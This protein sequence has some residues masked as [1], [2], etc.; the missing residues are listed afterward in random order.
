VR[1]ST[2]R[3]R[4]ILRLE[5]VEAELL[6]SLLGELT[7]VLDADAEDDA[8]VRP[9]DSDPVLARLYPS[10]YPEDAA[11]AADFRS[12]T[13]D[14]LRS[15]RAERIALCEGELARGRE[16]DLTDAE[17][18][19][20]WIKVLNDLRLSLGTRLGVTEEDERPDPADQPRMIYH[21]LTAVQDTVVTALM[22]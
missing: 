8:A 17:V 12:L 5:S 3:G 6:T 13:E 14:A 18:A 20:R 4:R 10:A 15:E 22:G 11:A 19:D 1:L 16:V 9:P 7:A 2:R 21:W